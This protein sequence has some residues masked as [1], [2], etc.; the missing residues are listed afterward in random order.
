MEDMPEKSVDEK[1]AE[2]TATPKQSVVKP[3]PPALPQTV[4]E[5]EA[6]Y[7][8][9]KEPTLND[10]VHSIHKALWKDPE[11]QKLLD[12]VHNEDAVEGS[13]DADDIFAAQRI[14]AHAVEHGISEVATRKAHT[15]ATA[16]RVVMRRYGLSRKER[17]NM[18]GG[19]VV[20]DG[21]GE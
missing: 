18:I 17:R 6:L 3:K 15:I 12:A 8:L 5:L 9:A 13:C 16:L 7:K 14:R 19:E 4:E 20:P 11:Y 21:N 1:S 10:Y 2:Q